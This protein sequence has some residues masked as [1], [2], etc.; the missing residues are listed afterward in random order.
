MNERKID[1]EKDRDREID[2]DGTKE[3]NK[4]RYRQRKN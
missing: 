2:S 3:I 4:E 1:S